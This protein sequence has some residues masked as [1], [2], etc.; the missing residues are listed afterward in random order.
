MA[1]LGAEPDT[2]ASW[3][4]KPGDSDL[5]LGRRVLGRECSERLPS[6]KTAPS[7]WGRGEAQAAR[8]SRETCAGH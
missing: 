8:Q 5:D 3:A 7:R 6:R 1:W 4:R 2:A